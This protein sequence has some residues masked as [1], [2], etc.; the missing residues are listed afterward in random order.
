MVS[1]HIVID[2]RKKL[3]NILLKK[4][5]PVDSK[6]ILQSFYTLKMRS[7]KQNNSSNQKQYKL[8][9]DVVLFRSCDCWY[10]LIACYFQ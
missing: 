9:Y 8:N 3:R 10:Q 7:L 4:L 2:L 1:L 6:I 5:T